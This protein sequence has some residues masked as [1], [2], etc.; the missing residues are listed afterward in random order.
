MREAVGHVRARWR[1]L[2]RTLVL[3]VVGAAAVRALYW[4]V[5][6]RDYVPY[7]DAAHYQE[8]A[9]HVAEGK[10]FV[11][12]FPQ[13]E[14]HDTAF[15]PPAFPFL[16]AG[17]YVVTWPAVGI[18]QLLNLVLGCAVVG[19]T[20]VL[21]K[22]VAGERA[23]AVS[24]A[25]V[26]LY[27]PLIA[28]DVVPLAESLALVVLLALALAVRRGAFLWAGVLAGVLVLTRTS[29]QAVVLIVAV[30]VGVR[31]GVRKGALTLGL[32]AIVILPWVIRNQVELGAPVLVTSNGFNLAAMHSEE[33]D[34]SGHFVDPV[35]DAR[36]QRFRIFQYD[37]VEWDRELTRHATDHIKDDPLS[38]LD[39]AWRNA[40]ALTEL[41]PSFNE[42]AERLDGRH[43]GFRSAMLPVFYLVTVLGLVGLWRVRHDPTV[44]FLALVTAYFVGLSLVFVAPPRLRA[45]FD[46]LCAIG[47]GILVSRL[48]AR[49]RDPTPDER[50]TSAAG[51]R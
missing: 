4:L 9:R 25:I 39:V 47:A 37:E 19:L 36:F 32:A 33:A 29:A 50:L 23:A 1:R 42:A 31:A 40:L 24:G 10:G 34:D 3:L 7:S 18:A 26:A 22:D 51:G 49:R 14:L 45:P 46:L 8:I 11:H 6:L 30:W 28:N 35:F 41:K 13:L 44:R 12:W 20:Y 43:A 48:A 27:P 21:V 17:L 38:V 15:R 5:F 16:L 2:D